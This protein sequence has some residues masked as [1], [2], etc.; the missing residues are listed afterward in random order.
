[1]KH[2]HLV[3]AAALLLPALFAV[4]MTACGEK[5]DE[6]VVASTNT[7]LDYQALTTEA[8]ENNE[9]NTTLW[10]EAV[11]PT[12]APEEDPDVA[13]KP[14]NRTTTT[15]NSTRTTTKNNTITT[16]KTTTTKN[17]TTI[18][19]TTTKRPSFT[20]IPDNISTTTA[21][22]TSAPSTASTASTASTTTKAPT[23]APTTT[24]P[25]YP[26]ALYVSPAS[27]NIAKGKPLQMLVSFAPSNTNQKGV[28]YR[29]SN[30][31]VATVNSNTGVVTAV[32]EGQCVITVISTANPQLQDTCQITVAPIYVTNF[33]ISTSAYSVRVGGLL[34]I[35]ATPVPSDASNSVNWSASGTGTNPG[36]GT[37]SQS[38]T[39][40]GTV[41][42]TVRI[43]VMSNDS[44]HFSKFID[45][46][47][48]A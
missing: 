23:T 32:G 7:T 36:A 1:M 22:P 37:I 5:P 35:D 18:P 45:I 30:T 39:F 8:T 10:W 47:V 28:I 17:P 44:N 21:R 27:A 13:P 19:V 46:T 29:S 12:V 16:T 26:L 15:K 11:D 34:N 33:N 14:G 40:I 48:V 41:P 2:M 4:S 3:K 6:P 9:E 43:T 20:T 38:G 31:S 25:I 42:G 24:V